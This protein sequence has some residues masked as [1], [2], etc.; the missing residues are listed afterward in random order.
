MSAQP[1]LKN[2]ADTAGVSIATVSMALRDDARISS[3][4]KTRVKAAAKRLGYK[5]NPL[6]S[7]YMA[8][9]RRT[10]PHKLH[11]T[12][13]YLD[14][15]EW[16]N[17][18]RIKNFYQGIF[19]GAQTRADELG[20]KLDVFTLGVRGMTEK[21]LDDVLYSR[22][23]QGLVIA[24]LP[25]PE[26]KLNLDWSRL[27]AVTIGHSLKSP[28]LHRV[29]PD[30]YQGMTL[31]IERLQSAGYQKIGL[32]I[33]GRDDLHTLDRFSAGYYWATRNSPAEN[34]VPILR[35]QE[36][37]RQPF[38]DWVRTHQPEIVVS[39]CRQTITWLEESGLK[40]PQ[41]IGVAHLGLDDCEIPCAGITQ[42]PHIIGALAIQMVITLLT[43]NERGIP[44]VP[45]TH[46]Y[47]CNWVP[48]PTI[49]M[50]AATDRAS[51]A[52][53]QSRPQRNRTQPTRTR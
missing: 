50:S 23:I 10:S 8:Q 41:D 7:A 4:T 3:A 1:T 26:D 32:Y 12:I 19:H 39:H 22:G 38:I 45:G 6:M 30:Q 40:I 29:A 16:K 18:P 13:G 2:I 47:P 11:G 25:P 53:P 33:V 5:P 44:T 37:S 46:T 28:C 21:R 31:L 36:L 24:P 49:R 51:N 42:Q 35:Q 34:R 14:P 9:L 43:I 48:G 17:K 20:F 27:S 52:S 15:F